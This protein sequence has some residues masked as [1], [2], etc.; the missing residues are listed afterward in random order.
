MQYRKHNPL[1]NLVNAANIDIDE[2]YGILFGEINEITLDENPRKRLTDA[3]KAQGITVSDNMSDLQFAKFTL[4]AF[5]SNKAAQ[6]AIANEIKTLREN[7]FSGATVGEFDKAGKSLNETLT[8]M[9]QKNHYTIDEAQKLLADDLAA[10]KSN[11][12]LPTTLRDRI[13]TIGVKNL[14][15]TAAVVSLIGFGCYKIFK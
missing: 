6:D 10:K 12:N 11:R 8:T 13:S 15:I 2:A 9:L 3:F 7:P 14:V 5:Y 4:D 1:V